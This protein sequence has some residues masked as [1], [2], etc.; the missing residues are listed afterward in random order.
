MKDAN[1]NQFFVGHCPICD[2]RITIDS[3][4]IPCTLQ[5]VCEK[6]GAEYMIIINS[7][8]FIR[9]LIS[10]KRTRKNFCSRLF[11]S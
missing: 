9:H 6:C 11:V 4:Y 8:T 10:T 1:G 5:Q 2:A 3:K 7:N